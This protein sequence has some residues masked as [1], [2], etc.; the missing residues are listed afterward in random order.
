[1]KKIILALVFI[2]I[3]LP[4]VLAINLKIEPD[5]D[6]GTLIYRLKSPAT[7]N[8]NVTNFGPADNIEFYNLLAFSMYPPGTFHI[9]NGETKDIQIIVYPP[10][11]FE[12]KGFYSFDYY[13][14]SQDGSQMSRNIVLKIIDLNNAFEIGA[15]EFNPE[16]NSIE[17]YIHNKEEFN[18]NKINAV[19]SSAF[20]KLEQEFSLEPNKRKDFTITLNKE[21]FNK[22]KAGFYTLNAVI[23]IEEQTAEIEGNINFVEKSIVTSEDK[24]FG[25]FISTK[26]ISKKNEGNTVESTEVVI[27]KDI[28][29]RLFT[30]FN[31]E[32]ITVKR[33]GFLVT[34][35]WDKELNPGEAL[36]IK[37]KTNWFYPLLIIFFIVIIVV[38]AKRYTETDLTLRKKVQF[39]KAK[40]GEFALKVSILTNAK[41]HIER[42]NIIDKLPPLVKVYGRFGAESP[43]RFDEKNR[44]I[45]W[46]FEKLEAGE[47]RVLS[48]I[49]YSKIGVL[50]K[51]ALPSATAI[52]EREGKIKESESNRAFFVAEQRTRDVEEG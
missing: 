52:Y 35:T 1:M 5:T 50:G 39:V 32:P 7:F 41:N 22:L 20:F 25:L 44:R 10:E 40:G 9:N 47:S 34:Y 30:S 11:E 24:Q 38:L 19:F 29:S 33:R 28:I 46:N 17:I 26:T 48:Y 4:S 23:K 2:S 51:F 14:R 3:I 36:N 42:V 15:K 12:Q 43:T 49:I 21:D 37:V 31:P 27:K 6:K 16:S 8:I 13:I 18:F 45:E